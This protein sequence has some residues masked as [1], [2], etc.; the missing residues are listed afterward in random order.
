MPAPKTPGNRIRDT[1]TPKSKSKPKPKPPTASRNTPKSSTA[2]KPTTTTHQKILTTFALAFRTRFNAHLTPS[3]QTLKHHLYSRDFSAAFGDP[4]GLEAYSVRWSA[5]RA[6]AYGDVFREVRGY[7]S[8]IGDGDRDGGKGRRKVV[9]LG[10][11][12]GA[13]VVALALG[14]L[15]GK[16]EEGWEWDIMVVDVAPWG[17]VLG[18][19]ETA[20]KASTSSSLVPPNSDFNADSIGTANRRLLD[21]ARFKVIFQQRDIL[22]LSGPDLRDLCR[23]TQMVTL[24]FTLNEL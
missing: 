23:D 3:I 22:A 15:G 20:M 14:A 4:A 16:D 24:M 2:S 1:S 19:L 18:K 7:L 10:G 11:G 8:G 9:C 5:G 13:E 6:V 12:A 21:P 17:S